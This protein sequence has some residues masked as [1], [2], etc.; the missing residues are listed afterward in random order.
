MARQAIPADVFLLP[1]E[2]IMEALYDHAGD[3]DGATFWVN[4]TAW[5]SMRN[6]LNL[7]VAPFAGG[8]YLLMREAFGT[9]RVAADRK[10]RDSECEVDWSNGISREGCIREAEAW[11][12]RALNADPA[13]VGRD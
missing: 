6:R 4:P 9:I 1:E 3:Y 11:M 7:D 13:E 2:Q 10:L 8:H 5:R 12:E